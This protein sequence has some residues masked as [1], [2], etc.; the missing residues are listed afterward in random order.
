MQIEPHLQDYVKVIMRRRWIILTFFTIFVVA[1][2]IVSLKQIPIYKSTTTILI[3]PRSPKVISVKEVTSMG[4]RDRGG[5]R[6][7][8][9]GYYDTQYKLIKS[10]LILKKAVA[11]LGLEY[12][13]RPRK[14][15][16][17]LL[18][19]G[20]MFLKKVVASI[21]LEYGNKTN[22]D[23]DNNDKKR[24]L[25]RKLFSAV[26]VNP[27]DKSQLVKISAEDPDPEMAAKIANSVADAYIR[28]NIER[29]INTASNAADWLSTKIGEQRQKLKDAELALA[30][31]RQEHKINILPGTQGGQSANE[32]VRAAYAKLQ[33]L[34][35]N[36]SQ[37]YTNE[38][39]KIIELKAQI[40][41]LRN[42]ISGLEDID[43]S[44][45]TIEYKVLERDVQTNKHMY[46]ILVSRL[47]EIDL[48]SSLNVNNISIID[49][50]E[51]T[52]RPIKPNL[53]KNMSVA[54][55]MG[56]FMGTGL[57]FFVD[58]LDRTIKS[59]QDIKNI[60]ESR[61][62]GS[63][64]EIKENNDIKKDKIVSLD[65]KS[66]ISEAYRDIR[67][68]ILYLMTNETKDNASA[69]LLITSAEPKAGKTMTT[70]NLGIALSQKG[71]RV[72]VVDTDLRKPQIHKI[73]GLDMKSGLS[74][75]LLRDIALDSIIKDTDIE[76]LKIVTSGK[77]PANPAEILSSAKMK[78]FIGD[79]K[80]K[81]DFLLF[82]SPPVT[83]VTDAVILADMVDALIQVVRSAKANIPVTL[84]AKEKLSN[85]GAKV[86]GVILN[87][88]KTYYDDYSYQ[89][90]Y[91]YDVEETQTNRVK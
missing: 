91:R 27:V 33:A 30:K 28:Q 60:L 48:S 31:Y 21:G 58:Y 17:S 56:L 41:S 47:K 75:Y 81:F 72:L 57:G 19:K 83:S 16:N 67:T 43:K 15:G 66:P 71:I 32:N 24:N 10:K 37:R 18:I 74:E 68:E 14:K 88:L 7:G 46:N 3:E 42:K 62:L 73:F 5:G 2:L 50:A 1:A 87:D 90:Y 35:A 89:R 54:V 22:K 49:R 36:Q 79:A 12:S 77:I 38:H 80:Q 85:T 34:L 6:S 69:A 45:I 13:N 44:N 8:Y 11:S 84:R 82:D 86:L 26:K 76:N 51:V 65:T 40:N 4:A 55:I 64:P 59:P 25:V 61:F 78:Q 39:P 20:K 29:N 52:K 23:L 53:P 70:T 63:I 9:Q